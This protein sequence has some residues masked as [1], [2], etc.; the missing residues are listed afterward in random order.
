MKNAASHMPTILARIRKKGCVLMLDFDGVLAPIVPSPTAATMLRRTRAALAACTVRVP[1][2]VITG[3]SLADIIRRVGIARVMYAGSHGL[4][5]NINGKI[6]RRRVSAIALAGFRAARRA[7]RAIASDFPGT[8]TE[9]K[10][11][12]LAIHYR[13]ILR[14]DEIRFVRAAVAA[15]APFVRAGAIRVIDSLYA[16]EIIPLAEWSKGDCALF[17]WR[18]SCNGATPVPIYIGDSLTDEDAFT[19]LRKDGITIRVGKTRESMARY[20]FA[21][22]REVDDFL[23]ALAGIHLHQ[24]QTGRC[25]D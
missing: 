19:A 12:C 17:I 14:R 11:H 5:W 21:T 4:E 24:N 16:F 20:Y 23:M 25:R 7:L 18:G 6:E 3:R 15:V 1:V 13:G 8:I 10:R 2:A 9:N 22:R